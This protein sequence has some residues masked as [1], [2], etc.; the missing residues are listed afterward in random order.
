MSRS[1]GAGEELFV[2]YHFF[3][4][5]SVVEAK[6]SRMLSTKLDISS[7]RK[8]Y[9]SCNTYPSQRILLGSS[10]SACGLASRAYAD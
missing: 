10:W 3:G 4:Q 5:K 6:K 9:K 7:C 2:T 1:F 8:Y